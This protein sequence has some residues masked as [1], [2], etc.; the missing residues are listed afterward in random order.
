MELR[1]L[2]RTGLKVSEIGLGTVELGMKYGIADGQ[3]VHMPSREAASRLLNRALDS[4]VNYIDTARAYGVSEEVIGAAL[5][6][7][8]KEYILASKVTWPMQEPADLQALRA[9]VAS[10]VGASLRALQTDAIDVMQLHSVPTEQV[11]RGEMTAILQDFQRAGSI[12]FLGATTYGQAAALAA[13]EDGRFDCIQIAYSVLDREPE[14]RTLPL[15]QAKDVGVVVRSVLLKGALSHR[16]R[17]LPAGLEELKSAVESV[18]AIARQASASL[19][20]FAYRYVLAHP[21]VA[22]ALVG[23]ALVEELQATLEY[24]ARGPLPPASMAQVRQVALRN[25]KLLNP[26]NWPAEA[27]GDRAAGR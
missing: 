3:T 21:A 25:P 12:R 26:G 1:R 7:R 13:L 19:P 2:G 16:H 15:A 24:G 20:E 4:G 17:Y 23:T 10:S 11:R 27:A 9:H 18:Q 14:F 6:R 22:T 5:K 8:R